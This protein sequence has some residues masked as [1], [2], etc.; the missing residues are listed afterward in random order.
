MDCGWEGTYPKGDG[1]DNTP[2]PGM[3]RQQECWWTEGR[4]TTTTG[5]VPYSH[6][7]IGTLQTKDVQAP[8]R[9]MKILKTK[10]SK[11][12]IHSDTS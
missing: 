10:K 7:D 9:E 6:T 5:P 3:V 4:V 2:H 1:S 8:R 11:V 12:Y